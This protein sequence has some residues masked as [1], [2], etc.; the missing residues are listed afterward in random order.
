MVW[1]QDLPLVS[2]RPDLHPPTPLGTKFERYLGLAL[3]KLN[4]PAGLTSLRDVLSSAD[5]T[6]DNLLAA[7]DFSAIRVALVVS[8]PG[9]HVGWPNVLTVGHTGLM[10]AVKDLGAVCPP[11]NRLSV[12][13]QV[14]P[15]PKITWLASSP[16]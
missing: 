1:I 7:Y 9:V 8:I 12:E 5:I 11:G 6:L 16:D 13:Y 2:K 3:A 10:D 14:C 4:V 15:S